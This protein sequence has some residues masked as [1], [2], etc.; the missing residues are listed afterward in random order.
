MAS[1]ALVLFQPN[2]RNIIM[3]YNTSNALFQP[4]IKNVTTY[5]STSNA[6]IEY[7]DTYRDSFSRSPYY[8]NINFKSNAYVKTKA[9][10]QNTEWNIASTYVSSIAP[11]TKTSDLWS[12]YSNVLSSY[13]VNLGAFSTFEFDRV[14]SN[15]Y[16]N[17]FSH[18]IFDVYSIQDKLITYPYKKLNSIFQM[19]HNFEIYDFVYIDK[20][21]F[22][23][24]GIANSEE[25][26]A[27]VGMVYEIIDED[28]F[29][30][31]TNGIINN[32]F[33]FESD[34]GIIYL[35]DIEPGKCTTYENIHS[36]LYTPLGFHNDNKLIVNILDSSI[37]DTLKLYQENFISQNLARLS[38][39]DI[40]DII[41]EVLDNL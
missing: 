22:Y 20:Y 33:E 13:I 15:I 1:K 36:M 28:N 40:N 19:N 31:M 2:I 12:T 26:Y 5:Y 14:N 9:I 3:Y 6:Y 41:Q 25:T 11:I 32:P 35:S 24:K 4:N 23:Q 17:I 29:V 27:V 34:S 39:Q 16:K 8:Y 7:Y 38:N 30:L 21:G 18:L 37:G 10:I